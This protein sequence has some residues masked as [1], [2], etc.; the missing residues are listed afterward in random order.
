[1]VS[2]SGMVS[3][4]KFCYLGDMLTADGGADSATVVKVKY[5]KKKSTILTFKRASL[6]LKSKVYVGWVRSCMMYGR[7]TWSMKKEHESMLDKRGMQMVRWM[8]GTS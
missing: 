1:M 8:F 3:V 5:T 7:E 6:K 4:G 2:I